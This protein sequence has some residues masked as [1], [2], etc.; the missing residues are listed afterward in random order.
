MLSKA[1]IYK[2]I[3]TQKYYYCLTIAT[4]QK[5]LRAAYC[6][7]SIFD[8]QNPTKQPKRDLS[9]A[10]DCI[11]SSMKGLFSPQ[12]ANPPFSHLC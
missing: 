3:K 8:Y 12:S 10:M 2:W 4:C 9:I 11:T 6:L 5:N 7:G 1:Y